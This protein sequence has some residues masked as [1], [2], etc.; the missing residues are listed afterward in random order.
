[1]E[2]DRFEKRKSKGKQK[3]KSKS[4]DPQRVKGN[5]RA[6]RAKAK[7]GNHPSAVPLQVT[8]VFIAENMDI[9]SVIAGS[10]MANLMGRA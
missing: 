8:N 4:K 3:G 2:V 10:F 5:Q 7:L 6:T 1:M 9:S